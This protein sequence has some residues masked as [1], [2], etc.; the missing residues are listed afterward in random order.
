MAIT[1]QAQTVKIDGHTSIGTYQG[2]PLFYVT[3]DTI[4]V[5]SSNSFDYVYID[6]VEVASTHSYWYSYTLDIKPYLDGEIHKLQLSY[7]E[8]CYITINKDLFV[9]G[10]Y[11]SIKD[12]T[13]KVT[14]ALY[15]IENAV[16]HETYTRDGVSYPVVEISAGVFRGKTKLKSVTIPNSV[17][18]IGN[19]AFIYCSGL[20]SVTIGNNVTSIGDC[21]FDGCSGLTSLTIPNSVTS[22]GDCAF[23]GCS[24]LTSVTIGNSVKSI[25]SYAFEGCSNLASITIPNSVESIGRY[26]FYFCI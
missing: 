9:D 12:E 24:G 16:I 6:D 15:D 14:G 5:R 17:E 23:D 13:A 21:A 20:T 26:A 10:I 22:I 25:G 1:S 4:T 2:Y 8:V 7:R 3:T 19:D 18:F 11:Y